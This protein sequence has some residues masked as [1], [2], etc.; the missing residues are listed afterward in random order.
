MARK[1][2]EKTIPSS[3]KVFIT[4]TMNNT[5]ITITDSDGNTLFTG[6]S[7]NAGFKGS[8]KS[9]PYAATKATETVAQKAASAGLRE[10][11]VIVKGPGMGRISSIKALKT[12]GLNVVA[13]SDMTPMPHNGCRPKK[14]RRV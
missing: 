1:K 8:R 11:S 13:I 9:T 14:K 7:G 6:S 4:A 5:I 12:A 3:G 10:V 2:K